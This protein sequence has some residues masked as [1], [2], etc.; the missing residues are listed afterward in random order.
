[1]KKI[2][3]LCSAGMSTSIVVKK[4][5][6]SAEKRGIEVEI[7]AVGL[8]MFQENLDKY[9]TFLLGPQVRFR[10]DELNAIAQEKG[11]KVEVINTMDYGMMKGDKILDF[12]LSLIEG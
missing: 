11:K 5:L 3:L 10:K 12:A 8:E 1:M 4:M 7:K 2:L 6:E 9:D